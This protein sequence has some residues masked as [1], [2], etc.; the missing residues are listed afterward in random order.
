MPAHN[1]FMS[2]YRSII[3]RLDVV[4]KG[5]DRIMMKVY[6][7]HTFI[8]AVKSTHTRHNNNYLNTSVEAPIA[9]VHERLPSV[10]VTA[11]RSLT[12]SADSTDRT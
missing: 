11:A 12:V 10:P 9:I 2:H 5:K 1:A 7:T 3:L 6:Y 4:E 8:I